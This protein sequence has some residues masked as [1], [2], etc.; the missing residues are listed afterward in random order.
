M[1][2][3][4]RSRGSASVA[5]VAVGDLSPLT[6]FDGARV[7]VVDDHA[8]NRELLG[9]YLGACDVRVQSARSGEEA[10]QLLSSTKAPHER[11]H[12]HGHDPFRL[13]IVD[14]LMPGMGGVELASAIREEEKLAALPLV[15]AQQ[16]TTV[17]QSSEVGQAAGFCATTPLCGAWLSGAR[18][19]RPP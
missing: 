10:L 6:S 1:R 18:E 17:P 12:D 5:D 15:L 13:V 11:G 19:P 3:V 9:D 14:E 16:P 7:L 4:L 2:V 8:V